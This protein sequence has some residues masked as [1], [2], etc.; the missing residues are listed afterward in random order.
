[1]TVGLALARVP[2]AL[3][4]AGHLPPLVRPVAVDVGVVHPVVGAEVLAVAVHPVVVVAAL[5]LAGLPGVRVV[6]VLL[7]ADAVDGGVLHAVHA[8]HG[9]VVAAH[10]GIVHAVGHVVVRGLLGVECALVGLHALV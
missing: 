2:A 9:A 3:L 5:D 6:G 1:M 7:A 8:V 10:D 4:V